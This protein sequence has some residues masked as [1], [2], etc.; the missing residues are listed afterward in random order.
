MQNIVQYDNLVRKAEGRIQ[1]VF[2][3]ADVRPLLEKL[4]AFRND[5]T[6]LRPLDGLA[7]FASFEV[8]QVI[9]LPTEVPIV[10]EVAE[11][12]H[13]RPL[14]RAEQFSGRYHV[15]CLAQGNVSLYEGTQDS[16][17]DVPLRGVPA[18]IDEAIGRRAVRTPPGE[19]R[20]PQN[21][22]PRAK[23]IG[24]GMDRD[25][26]FRVIDKAVWENHSRPSGLPLILCAIPSYHEPFHRISR[27][28]HL[29]PG[30]I[31]LGPEGLSFDRLHERAWRMIEPYYRRDL[32]RVIDEYGRARGRQRGSEDLA[33]VAEAVAMS[34]VGTLL[35][36]ADKHVGGRIDPSG[37]IEFGDRSQPQ[38]DDLLDDIAE[39]VIRTG[40]QVLIMPHHHMPT[41]TGIAAI[42]RF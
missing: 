31:K 37:R 23:S 34:R 25:R 29:L 12:F 4:R 38:F 8:F 32:D 28:A 22:E 6:W 16:L 42:Y 14:I 20:A 11:S 41:D 35:V 13:L 40:G 26:F 9:K 10:V 21:S 3:K 24:D 18:N 30:S 5:D 7:V 2:R 17:E 39:R 33:Q 1:G 19:A 27:N 15:L 36:D